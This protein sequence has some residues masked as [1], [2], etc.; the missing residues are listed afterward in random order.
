MTTTYLLK[1]LQKHKHIRFAY[2]PGYHDHDFAPHRHDFSELFIVFDGSGMH[3]VAGHV[4]PL[5]KGDVFVIN[6]EVE[7]GFKNVKSLTIVDLM[8]DSKAPLFES[9]QLKLLPGY[10][11]LFN[12]DPIAR[13]NSEYRA[14]LTLSPEQLEHVKSLLKQ[15]DTEYNQAPN[16]FETMLASLM[17]QLIITLSR[18]YQGKEHE[19]NLQTLAL[20]R[21]MVHI[22]QHYSNAQLNSDTIA[23]AAFVSKRQME[24]LFRQ[25]LQT[26]PNQYIREVRLK[27]AALQ[28]CDDLAISIQTVS[29]RCGFSDSNYFSRSFKKQ[30]GKSPRQFRQ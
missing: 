14:K 2:E 24:R 29:E 18:A 22:E 28:L 3:E 19:K 17:Q 23:K 20:S 4:Y 16:G 30:Y 8:F 25:F 1:S 10:Q 12:V 6:G 26:S 15:I 9:P 13:L 21:A 5:N 11:A 7:H 27:H